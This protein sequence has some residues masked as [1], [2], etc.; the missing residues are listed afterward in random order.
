[1][2]LLDRHVRTVV[3]KSIIVA[4]GIIVSLELIFSLIDELGSA[5]GDYTVVHAIVFVAMT[6]P[7][8]IYEMFPFATLGGTIFGLGILASGN[9]VV[10]MQAAGVHK[11]RI[12]T[13]VLKPALVLMLIGLVIGEYVS[14]PL[15]QM[16]NS[17][18]AM[19]LSGTSSINAETGT[20]RKVGN[21]FIHINAIAPGGRLLYG[22]SRYRINEDREL[23]LADFAES[24]HYIEE[25]G[26]T[27]WLMSNGQLSHF[28]TNNIT[29]SRYQQQKWVVDLSPELLGVLLVDPDRQSVSGLYRF[30]RFF[31]AEGLDSAIYFLAFWKKILQPLATLS[32]VVLAVSFVF[33]PLREATMGYRVFIALC[34]GIAFT[35]IQRMM[36]PVSLIYGLSPLL[37]VMTPI[38]LCAFFGLILMRRVV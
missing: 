35:T 14:P 33:G 37:A 7:T 16:A 12:V 10:V 24:A 23:A 36:E 9:E 20:W 8:S 13:A 18:K 1:M 28:G 5:D 38:L 3:L 17:N 6:T 2:Q 15:E 4:L 19:R 32:L 26:D 29:T 31:Q 22:V 21:E 25:G 11:W 30:A 27:Y 34:I